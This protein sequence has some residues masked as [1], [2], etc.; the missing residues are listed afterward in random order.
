MNSNNIPPKIKFYDN[1]FNL[2]PIL[3][4]NMLSIDT[5]SRLN[6]NNKS[7]KQFAPISSVT[8]IQTPIMYK[9]DNDIESNLQRPN[10][11]NNECLKKNSKLNN[12]NGLLLDEADTKTLNDRFNINCSRR[13]EI[14]YGDYKTPPNQ[15]NGSGF[16]NPEKYHETYVGINTRIDL[17]EN[18][19]NID[20]KD[21]N[22]I[23]LDSFKINYADIPYNTDS[24]CGISTRTY[25]KSQINF[26]N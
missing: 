17:T 20:L 4:D 8:G 23:P 6:F 22:I 1:N 9:N 7:S 3:P 15:S 24:R 2:T 5:D 18:S 16:G 12:I 19:R 11:Y 26:E 10:N 14:N 13:K 21:R 25:K